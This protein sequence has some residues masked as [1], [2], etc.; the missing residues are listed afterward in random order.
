METD[1]IMISRAGKQSGAQYLAFK[2][3]KHVRRERT[4][5]ESSEEED[6]R[7]VTSYV[8]ETIMTSAKK[9]E[10]KRRIVRV[11]H[12]SSSF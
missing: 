6:Y 7:E 12:P 10:M 4:I 3:S 2:K 11:K 1:I 9:N 5:S 8:N